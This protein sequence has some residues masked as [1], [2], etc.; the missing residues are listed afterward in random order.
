MDNVSGELLKSRNT[1]VSRYE[2]GLCQMWWF[3]KLT[4]GPPHL[5]TLFQFEVL[6]LSYIYPIKA[7]KPARCTGGQSCALLAKS[8]GR[9]AVVLLQSWRGPKENGAA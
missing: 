5:V 6:F 4:F 3:S 7:V 9:R 2:M 1:L 8:A